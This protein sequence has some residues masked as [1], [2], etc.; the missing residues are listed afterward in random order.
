[1]EPLRGGKL[2]SLLPSEAKKRMAESGRGWSP[3]GWAFR[4]LF[5]QP[6]V[7]VVLSGMNSLQMVEENC[8]TASEAEPG[9]KSAAGDVESLVTHFL[10]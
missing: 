8:R 3:A 5:N 6:E 7:T 9:K 4:W 10:F 1:M 2:V